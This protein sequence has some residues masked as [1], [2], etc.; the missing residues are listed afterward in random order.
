MDQIDQL[1]MNLKT[2]LFHIKIHW[3]EYL[4]LVVVI[5]RYNPFNLCQSNL[6]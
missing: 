5:L 1:F 6:F 3:R 4:S 2:K